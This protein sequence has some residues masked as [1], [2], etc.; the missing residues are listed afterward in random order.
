MSIFL[1]TSLYNSEHFL[2][3]NLSR[4][5]VRATN[6]LDLVFQNMLVKMAASGGIILSSINTIHRFGV[7]SGI[8]PG[9]L[10][11]VRHY[12][13]RKGTREKAKKKKVKVEVK[14][15]TFEEKVR[16]SKKINIIKP[17]AM[18]TNEHTKP[19]AVD[20]VFYMRYFRWKVYSFAEAIQNHREYFHPTMYDAPDS[21]VCVNAELNLTGVK[22][23]KPVGTFNKIVPVKHHFDHGEERRLLAFCKAEE[24]VAAALDAGAVL[25]GGSDIIKLI[26]S[27]EISIH[28][29]DTVVA[30][31]SMMPEVL[32]LRGLLKKKY[33]NIKNSTLGMDIKSIVHLHLHGIKYTAK[34]YEH[35]PEYGVAEV[36]IGKLSME[37][38]H[39]EDNLRSAIDSILSAKPKRPGPFITR[40]RIICPPSLEKFK[41]DD[42]LYIEEEPEVKQTEKGEDDEYDDEEEVAVPVAA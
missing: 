39:L 16:R 10:S 34:P 2:F 42:K 14:K 20:D 40:L 25:A 27:G 30:H 4:N 32:T 24:D 13:A 18:I 5:I 1:L 19:V 41:I 35:F 15:L 12:A 29:Y 23:T 28:N 8:F 33:P 11:Q 3:L 9:V 37:T 31:P 22:K 6:L 17:D 21:I 26:L 7:Y 36:P 38:E